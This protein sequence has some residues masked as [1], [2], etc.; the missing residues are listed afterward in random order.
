MIIKTDEELQ[1][2]KKAGRIVAEIR[3]EMRQATKPGITTKELDELGGQLFKEKGGVSGP[4]SEYDFPGYTC[5]SVNDEV[6]HGIP[7]SR[8]IQEGDLVNIDVSGS[9]DGYFADTG[10]S[11]VVGEGDPLLTKLCEAA[12]QAFERGLLKAKAGSKQNQIGKAVMNEAR[13][14]GFT[15]IKNLTGH[16]I[17]RSLH[18]APDHI[19]NYFDPWDNALLKEGMVIAFEPFISAKADMIV[20]GG[21]GWT[22]K[23]PD[24]SLVAQIEHTIVITKDEPIILTK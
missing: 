22:F 6:A 3:D 20:E 23:T 4:K 5:I 19:L 16:G 7:G 11:F 21:D 18:E 15:V 2:L 24:G 9:Y 13:R 1:A 12:E 14:H 10:I 17:G 8:V